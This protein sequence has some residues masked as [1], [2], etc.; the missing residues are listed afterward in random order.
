M[1]ILIAAA[2]TGGHIIPALNIAL[3]LKKT[4]FQHQINWVGTPNGMENTIVSKHS[5]AMHHIQFSGVRKKGILRWLALPITLA[6]A[7][8][9]ACQ[10]LKKIKPDVVLVMGGYVSVPT[11]IAAFFKRI[12]LIIHEQNSIPGLAN[13]FCS[14]FANK[15]CYAFPHSFKYHNQKKFIHTGN[16]INPLLNF[17]SQALNTNP[18]NPFNILIVGGS[19]GAQKINTILPQ[20]L[21]NLQTKLTQ[22]LSITHQCG[23][24]NLEKTQQHYQ[25]HNTKA[26]VIEFSDELPKLYQQANLI[27]ARAGAMSV[28]EIA[29][30]KC[31]ALFI[32]YPYAV[33]DH[34]YY[35]ALHLTKDQQYEEYYAIIRDQSLTIENCTEKLYQLY[36]TIQKKSQKP[37]SAIDNKSALHCHLSATETI[38]DIIQQNMKS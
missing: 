15:V 19:L 12:P 4:I 9:Q 33:N 10:L 7:T 35:N 6:Q 11:A 16:P 13:K 27:I 25:Q 30:I 18:A 29:S 32:P 5:I 21:A 22:P 38:V 20:A 3:Y 37:L 17:P 8:L 26:N 28:A 2:G 24:N 14:L 34:Q 36:Q 1:N 23:K 31:P